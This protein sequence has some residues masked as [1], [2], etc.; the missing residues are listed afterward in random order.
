V[1]DGGRLAKVQAIVHAI[2]SGAATAKTCFELD[3]GWSGM[4]VKR[5]GD[6][7]SHWLEASDADGYFAMLTF[8]NPGTY[9]LRVVQRPHRRWQ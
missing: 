1:S 6:K 3:T 9:T 7:K 5:A 8:P 4:G 2:T